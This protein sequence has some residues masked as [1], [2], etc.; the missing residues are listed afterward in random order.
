M[1]HLVNLHLRK[2]T[3]PRK[4]QKLSIYFADIAIPF[5]KIQ[6]FLFCWFRC[7]C[8]TTNGTKYSRMDQVKFV[9]D[10]L[11]KI[12]RGKICIKQTIF[13]QI[14]K[15]CLPQIL[16][17]PFL[18]TLTQIQYN[19]TM[20]IMSYYYLPLWPKQWPKNIYILRSW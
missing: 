14:F 6:K 18:N 4:E 16:F 2:S 10:S 15:G 11:S 5:F 3:D 9:K 20:I 13:L 17:G 7:S 1:Q 12:W 8:F 19:H